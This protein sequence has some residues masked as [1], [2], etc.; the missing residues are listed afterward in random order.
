MQQLQPDH[1]RLSRRQLCQSGFLALAS[2]AIPPSLLAMSL[3]QILPA[4]QLSF[5]NTHTGEKLQHI[6]YWAKGD[7]QLDALGAI[8]H[9]LRDHRSGE[10]TR[11]DYRLLD[12]L[13]LLNH[14]LDN[15]HPL[16]VISGYRSAQTNRK[17]RKTGGGVA[18]YSLHMDGRAIDLRL[19]NREL[20]AVHQ[21]A[22]DLHQGGVGYYPD[23]Q[24]IHLDTGAVRHW[25]GA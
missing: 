7:Y 22:I 25:S 3:N 18:K 24:F 20:T 8:D 13:W 12:Q 5:F 4:R 23:S 2:L 16:H 19:P 17:L 14:R 9:I 21:A 11:I 10:I 6:D 1:I 15:R